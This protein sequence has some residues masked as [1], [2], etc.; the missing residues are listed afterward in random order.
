MNLSPRRFPDTI[1]RR[2]QAPG[3]RNNFGEWESGATT[4]TTLRASVQPLQIE[5]SDLP[6]GTDVLDRVK[7]YVPIPDALVAAF[8]SAQA[9]EV[10]LD[11]RTYDVVESRSWRRSHT[12]ATL[13][14]KQTQ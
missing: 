13:L 10:L 5:D 8:D 3:R 14:R 6:E 11:G 7:V 1:T 2:R 4:E 9:D 12:R